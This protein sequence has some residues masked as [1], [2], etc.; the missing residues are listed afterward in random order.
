MNKIL[1]FFIIFSSCFNQ[2]SK[3][4]STN[5]SS[6]SNTKSFETFSQVLLDEISFKISENIKYSL[7][8]YQDVAKPLAKH[9][10]TGSSHKYY[11]KVN[12]TDSIEIGPFEWE[13]GDF[14][15]LFDE[16]IILNRF[17]NWNDST[18]FIAVPT[19]GATILYPI[20]KRTGQYFIKKY[21]PSHN[22]LISFDY[23]I[24]DTKRRLVFVPRTRAHGFE[25]GQIETWKY[26]DKKNKWTMLSTRFFIDSTTKEEIFPDFSDEEIVK[27]VLKE[28]KY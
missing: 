22:S 9:D 18:V 17:V 23:F 27:R 4:Y 15:G 5:D 16:N 25:N 28:F 2:K 8:L 7:I 21:G 19:Y 6:A 10:P 20:V 11:L 3:N 14:R 26:N 13:M 12:S 24:V 1:I